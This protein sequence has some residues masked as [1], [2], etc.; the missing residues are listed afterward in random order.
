MTQSKNNM[1]VLFFDNAYSIKIKK[2]RTNQYLDLQN[3]IGNY[4]ENKCT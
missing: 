4:E 3:T 2:S 1:L